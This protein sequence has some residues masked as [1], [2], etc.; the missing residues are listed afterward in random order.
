MAFKDYENLDAT[1]ETATKKELRRLKRK[2]GVDRKCSISM[3]EAVVCLLIT[4]ILTVTIILLYGN[5]IK[6][7]I[8]F[9]VSMFIAYFGILSI[10]VISILRIIQKI[11]A[12]W[13]VCA[14]LFGTDALI[15]MTTL[16]VANMVP[17]SGTLQSVLPIIGMPAFALA[18]LLGY[19]MMKFEPKK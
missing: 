7:S 1:K 5:V 12:K 11:N 18:F 16:I 19:L 15:C 14:A 9:I 2:Y 17:I 4:F 8:D 10:V 3:I 13:Y 6:L